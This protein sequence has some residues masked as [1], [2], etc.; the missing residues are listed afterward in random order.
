[1]FECYLLWINVYSWWSNKW[2][3]DSPNWL[4]EHG[5]IMEAKS[6][7]IESTKI[8]KNTFLQNDIDLQ[9]KTASQAEMDK[10]SEGW[11]MIWKEKTAIKNLL[12]VHLAWSIF[13]VVYYGMLLNIRAFGRD[14][15]TMNTIIAGA[16]EM[17]GTFG[18]LYLIICSNKKWFWC[19]LLNIAGGLIAYIAWIIPTN[20]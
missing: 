19:G 1:M 6:V 15:L 4:L 12:R 8:N 2:I 9:L 5:R 3:P 11:W 16:C 13:I 20:K 18:G 17:I 14:H 7:L 10:V